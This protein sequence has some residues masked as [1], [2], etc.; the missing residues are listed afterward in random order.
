VLVAFS[1]CHKD[2]DACLKLINWCNE[3][4]TYP[5]HQALIVTSSLI[6]PE[7][8]STL[9]GAAQKSFSKVWCIRQQIP[10]ESG[11]PGSCNRMFQ[12]AAQWVE[13]V[14]QRPW[15]WL[16]SDAAPLRP[17]WLDAIEQEYKASDKPFMGTVFDWIS[18]TNYR[19][20]LTGNAVYP[21][22]IKRINPYALT[23]ASM[24]WD[25][26]RPDLTLPRTHQTRLICHRWGNRETNEPPTFPDAISLL[27]I[28]DDAVIFHRC[29][30]GTLID[31]MREA[32]EKISLADVPKPEHITF[33]SIIR[34]R[35][36]A[37]FNG[38][39]QFGHAGN[40]G[41]VIYALQAI[42]AYGGGDLVISPE[43]RNTPICTVPITTE[44]F[45]LVEPLLRQQSYLRKTRWSST[46]PTGG[47]D[48][49]HFRKFW[50][51]RGLKQRAGLNTLAK[52]HF[53]ELGILDQFNDEDV[54]LTVSNP[55]ST[56]KIVI[57][58][59]PRYNSDNFPWQRLVDQR[60]KDLLFIGL[61]SE[62]DKFQRD[63]KCQ[64]SFWKCADFLEMARV[65]KGSRAFVGNQSF[66]LS[67]ALGLG[68]EVICEEC[69][70]S[71]DCRYERET[72]VGHLTAGPDK[73]NFEVL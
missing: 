56:G 22:N 61:N 10:D 39:N 42:K 3:L 26:C 6:T 58:R 60:K 55:I 9:L 45:T 67:L 50:V 18:A 54:W 52:A 17:G 46:Y 66:P 57:H 14:G 43:Q 1:A 25:T 40:L 24:P 47:H 63:F 44:Q 62:H 71:P 5:N 41:D 20:H 23:T 53:Y 34:E 4:D 7:Q 30:D 32:R 19:P 16:E 29:K 21:A 59:S 8:G 31:R 11:W 38:A 64:V 65:I 33:A 37:L 27:S 15:L 28:P 73:L 72:Y 51:D 70:R 12:L 68:K 13:D 36:S 35:V 69:P 2:V 48:M 49:N